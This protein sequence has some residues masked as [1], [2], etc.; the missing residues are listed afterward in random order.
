[1]TPTTMAGALAQQNAEALLGIALLQLTNPGTPVVYGGF[2]SNVDMRSGSPAFG[3]PEN[4]LANIAGGQLA[5]RYKLPYRSSACNASNAVDAQAIYETQMALWGAVMGHGNLIYHTAGWLEGGLVASFE[6]LIIDCEML[7]HMSKMLEPIKIDLAE[8]GLEAMRE[9]GP[10][11]HF[12]G[13]AH[14]L[15]RY[16]D[17]FYEPF[18]SDWQN[19]E[20]WAI[21]GSKNATERATELWPKV[22]REFAPPA[23]DPAIEEELQAYMAKRKEEL[24]GV[25]PLVEPTR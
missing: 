11:G 19:S 23:V 1:M 3:T 9:V 2:T 20:N 4:A 13:C 25:E 6:K 8:T 18:I 15:E 14:T 7:Q 12:F 24:K 22:L 10:G 21:A 17:A 16:K 5:R